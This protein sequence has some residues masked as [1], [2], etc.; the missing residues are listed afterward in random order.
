MHW[1]T[2]QWLCTCICMM[3]EWVCVCVSVRVSLISNHIVCVFL[4]WFYFSCS[5]ANDKIKTKLV[6]LL[7]LSHFPVT[8]AIAPS[9]SVS[10]ALYFSFSLFISYLV[11]KVALIR[12]LSQF[13]YKNMT[14]DKLSDVLKYCWEKYRNKWIKTKLKK[15]IIKSERYLF[16]LLAQTLNLPPILNGS[17]FLASII[18]IMSTEDDQAHCASLNGVELS[19]NEW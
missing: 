10:L 19:P 3:C 13:L 1:H 15:K 6:I 4:V 18:W 9:L 14:E 8:V 16:C 2:T 11:M 17:L 12:Q 7:I 5:S